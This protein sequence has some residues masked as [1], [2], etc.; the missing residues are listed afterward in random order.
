MLETAPP[1]GPQQDSLSDRARQVLNALGNDTEVDFQENIP[2]KV[3]FPK[4]WGGGD[5]APFPG[6]LHHRNANQS[7]AAAALTKLKTYT[8]SVTSFLN[9]P[10]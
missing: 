10:L 1:Q 4:K 2:G 9:R 8:Y 3:R 5:M 7:T 6:S